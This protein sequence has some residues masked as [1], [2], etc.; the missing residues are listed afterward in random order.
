MQRYRPD[1]FRHFVFPGANDNASGTAVLLYLARYY[2]LHPARYSVAFMAFSGEEAGLVGSGYYT[3]HPVFPLKQIRIVVNLDMAGDAT[4][5]ITVVNA[6]GVP[7]EYQLLEQLNSQHRYLPSVAPRG[8]AKNSDHY[9][10]SEKGV[11]AFYIY[12]NGIKPYYHDL[13]DTAE[14]VNFEQA[15][16]LLALLK[17]F[18]KEL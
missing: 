5:G 17:E 3:A 7:K 8:Q 4:R 10:F 11:P 16:G 12:T 6:P 2:A 18:V 9:S 15:E 1:L 14:E 13:R